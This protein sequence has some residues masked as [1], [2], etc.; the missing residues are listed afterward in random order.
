MIHFSTLDTKSSIDNFKSKYFSI[1]EVLFHPLHFLFYSCV[2]D[3]LL[4]FNTKMTSQD[5]R[6]L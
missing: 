5:V 1:N 2:R 4:I 3:S 6:I